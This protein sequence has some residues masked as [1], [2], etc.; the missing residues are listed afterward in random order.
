MSLKTQADALLRTAAESGDVPGVV[1]T[2]TDRNGTIYEGGFG[3]RALGESAEMTPDTVVWIASMTKALTGMAAMQLVEQGKL[4]LDSPVGNVIPALGEV[5]VLEG[6]DADHQPRT[7]K[8]KRALTLRHLLTHTA[9]F[10]YEF[11]NAD[12][13]SCATNRS[14][15]YP[16]LSVARTQRCSYCCTSIQ[17]IAGNT[18][19]I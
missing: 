7:R 12:V 4:S 13:M 3:L 19:S 18:A 9:G 11:W 8:P 2:A 17:V 6:F 15:A 16:L 14:R 10:A 1:A 5:E